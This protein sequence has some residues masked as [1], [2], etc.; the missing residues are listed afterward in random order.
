MRASPPGAVRR[1]LVLALVMLGL[2]LLGVEPGIAYGAATGLGLGCLSCVFF[3]SRLAHAERLSPAAGARLMRF[4]TMVR[5]ILIVAVVWLLQSKWPA[6]NIFAV[7]T[8]FFAAWAVFALAM[9][10]KRGKGS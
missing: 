1:T 2:G 5:F 10:E 3:F 9:G 6:V 8:G 7:L 4:G